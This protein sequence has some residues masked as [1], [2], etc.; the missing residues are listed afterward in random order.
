MSK[1]K[2]KSQSLPVINPNAAEIDIGSRF[3]VVAVPPDRSDKSAQ[4]FKAFT[5]DIHN[6]AR[7]LT[8]CRITTVAMEST[9]V[10]WVPYYR[11]LVSH[12]GI[13]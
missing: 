4:T 6:M 8:K 11:P 9:S 10:Y 7:W 12:D 13:K 2:P 5:G 1:L 3:H